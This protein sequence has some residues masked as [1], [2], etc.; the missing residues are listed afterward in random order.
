MSLKPRRH[1]RPT[2]QDRNGPVPR[3]K[4]R[5]AA[6]QAETAGEVSLAPGLYLV[7]TPIGNLGDIGARA[8]KVLG[9]ADLV[10]C[11]DTRTT[12]KL[13]SAYGLAPPLAAYHEHNAARVRPGLIARIKAGE[14][15]ALVS[16]A[17]TPLISDPGYKLVRA[18]AE[19]GL[20]VTTV[21]GPSAPLAALTISGLPSD[22]FMFAGFL[23][24]KTAARRR[25]LA[26]L[27]AV[28]ATLIFFETARRLPATLSAMAEALG[29]REAAVAREMTK[30]HEEVRRDTLEALTAHYAAA[31]PPK[32]EV[33]I[34]VGPPEDTR[35][36]IAEAELDARLG[37]ALSQA[38]SLRDAVAAVAA[39]TGLPRQRVYARALA[40]GGRR[41]APGDADA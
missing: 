27:K 11:E 14:A 34:V 20:A 25:D 39:E 22:R 35:A 13:L 37:E 40:L 17:G 36:E 19:A 5:A 16:D 31:G 9:G 30:L 29:A 12:R 38:R 26:A 2:R 24:A 3:S 4:P 8:L 28:P 23:P 10:A 32:G 33:V 21:P 6:S 1:P 7:A 41:D 18:A 15:V